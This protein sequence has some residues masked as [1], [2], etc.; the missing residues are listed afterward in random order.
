MDAFDVAVIGAG[1]FGSWTAWHLAQRGKRV[2]LLDAYGPA[3]NRASSGGESRI[4]RMGYGND[5]IYTAWARRSLGMWREFL[6]RTGL[7]LF[8]Q[9]AVLWL[10]SADGSHAR[11]TLEVFEKLGIEHE[12]LTRSQMEQRYP[13]CDLGE[14]SWGILEPLSGALMARRAVQ[15]VVDDA[16][17]LRV[18]Y[19]RS[20][21]VYD[22]ARGEAFAL[23][24]GEPAPVTAGTFVFACGP[25]LP[26]VFPDPLASRM[27]ITRQE[28]FFF[29]TPPGETRFSPPAMPVWLDSSADAY[30]FPELE[31]RGLKVAQDQHGPRF[32]PDAGERV[33]SAEGLQAIRKYV[34]S[35]FPALKNSPL[36][37]A[38]V[39]QYEN[40]SSGDFL[41]DRHPHDDRVWLVGGG[42]GHGFKHGPVLGEF[43]AA[44]ICDGGE[45]NP[46]FSLESKATVQNR[47]VF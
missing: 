18:T 25:W 20:K 41:I 44:L 22:A 11:R 7:P 37:E 1:A 34:A 36:V 8:H 30:G 28:I 31:G 19:R 47:A 10:A 46:R 26:K 29:G 21:V 40:T 27:F 14:I 16:L 9:T 45:V 17:Q 15:A 13:Q 4:I 32:D 12:K 39:C 38:R 35:R 42:S 43:V 5:E 2:L 23:T 3:H 6:G 33:P 24:S